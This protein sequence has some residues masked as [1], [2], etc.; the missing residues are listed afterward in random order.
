MADDTI[1]TD[2]A[3][4]R[5]GKILRSTSLIAGASLINIAMSVVRLKVL[6]ILLGPAGI[7][8]FGIYNVISDLAASLV[9]LGV[10]TSGVRQVAVALSTDD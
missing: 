5:Y 7:G 10:Q 8:L 4:S 3:E 1:E 2:S 6:A 9:G